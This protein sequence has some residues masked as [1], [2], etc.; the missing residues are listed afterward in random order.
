MQ[1]E[2]AT[3]TDIVFGAGLAA[4]AGARIASFGTQ[5]ARCDGSHAG[6]RVERS[7][8]SLTEAGVSSRER[9]PSRTSRR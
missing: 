6:S 8:T 9:T 5:G 3:A 4:S 7:L 1:F 2:F